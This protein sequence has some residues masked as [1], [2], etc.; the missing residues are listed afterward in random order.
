MILAGRRRRNVE[1]LEDKRDKKA[2]GMALVT[3]PISIVSGL[4][5]SDAATAT[6][7]TL[8]TDAQN[9][10]ANTPEAGKTSAQMNLTA[11]PISRVT[12][13]SY[14]VRAGDTVSKIARKFQLST[15]QLIQI[16][17]LG[18]K[19]LIVPGQKLKLMSDAIEPAVQ[20]KADA[21][22]VHVV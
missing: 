1:T 10:Q 16:N 13:L 9:P 12:Q 3:V 17:N 22:T 15:N 8:N 20:K 5:G 19:A 7:T 21:A 14:T 6:E 11:A 2:L 4:T 18:A